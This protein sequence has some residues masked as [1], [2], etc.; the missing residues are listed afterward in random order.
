MS[1]KFSE[2]SINLTKKILKK[3]KN[4]E[5]IFF[6]PIKTIKYNIDIIKKYKK[7]I[8]SILEPSCGS[9][10]YILQINKMLDN[11]IITGIEKNK[12]IF[13]NIKDISKNNISLINDDFLK[14]KINK[15]YD[16]VLG[17]PPYF[18]IKKKEVNQKYYDYFEGRPNIFILFIIKSLEILN[19]GGILSFILPKNFLNSLYYNKT[20]QY[21]YKYYKILEI[22]NCDDNYIET[23]Q[24]TIIFVVQNKYENNY[25]EQ[26]TFKVDK[27][28]IFGPKENISKIKLLTQNCTYLNI[29]NLKCQVGK[30]VWNQEKE[31]LTDD[32]TKTRLIYSTDIISNKLEMKKYI[33]IQK[34]N[35]IDKVGDNK[36][37]LII[38]RGYGKGAYKF[39]YCIVDVN[40]NYV[41]ENH[42][43]SIEGCNKKMY[44]K[45]IKSF[46]DKRTKQFIQNYFG[47]NAINTTELNYILP[48][49]I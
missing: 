33:N 46:E 12:I 26:Y 40:F 31:K 24:E 6:T 20:R 21:I 36:C 35:Y 16:L 44:E 9:C 47:N 3:D 5:G 1:D 7:D 27:Y 32:N 42:I 49:F 11:C 37:R 30:I 39:N 18:V 8:K 22:I 17:N 23:K 48:I 19:E 43:I 15:K 38:N 41:L 14:I 28:I 29:L 4:K 2:L 13:N 25:N 10:E 45:I 34:K